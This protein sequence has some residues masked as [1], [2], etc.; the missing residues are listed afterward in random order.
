MINMMAMKKN[1][2]NSCKRR[3][4]YFTELPYDGRLRPILS[5][6]YGTKYDISKILPLVNLSL[7][8]EL[9]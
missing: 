7:D 5:R 3:G 1:V 4:C 8:K 2:R 9:A 6:V